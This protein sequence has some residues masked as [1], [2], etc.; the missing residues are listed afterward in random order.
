M[1]SYNQQQ[2]KGLDEFDDIGILKQTY[3]YNPTDPVYNSDGTYYYAQRAFRYFN[4]IEA[5]N[6]VSRSI[7][8]DQLL[9]NLNVSYAIID[10][11]KVSVNAAYSKFDKKNDLYIPEISGLIFPRP[12]EVNYAE[13]NKSLIIEG[14]INYNFSLMDAT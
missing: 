8:N 1:A 12:Q 4:P 11:L 6:E 13:Y 3:Q 9:S 14:I 5:N 2:V 10:N 7:T